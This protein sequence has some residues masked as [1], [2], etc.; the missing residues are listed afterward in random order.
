MAGKAFFIFYPSKR[1][2]TGFFVRLAFLAFVSF[3]HSQ[4]GS[5]R[6]GWLGSHAD[7][8]LR[9]IFMQQDQGE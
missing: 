2:Q 7:T 1:G 3:R 5:L 6:L 8:Q 9:T 4:A